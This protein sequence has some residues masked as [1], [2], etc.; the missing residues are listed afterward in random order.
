MCGIVGLR[1]LNGGLV[2]QVMLTK[3]TDALAYLR[4]DVNG[5]YIDLGANIGLEH[6]RLAI[7]DTS[8][9][10]QHHVLAK[11]VC[12]I[13]IKRLSAFIGAWLG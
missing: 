13:I 2:L 7:I 11:V 3:F 9:D 12:G 4:P 8:D 6:R 10:G 5:V 1:N